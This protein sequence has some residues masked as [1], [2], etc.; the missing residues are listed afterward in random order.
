M[1]FVGKIDAQKEVHPTQKRPDR[2]KDYYR[3]KPCG[4]L[5]YV[6][7]TK[8]VKERFPKILARLAE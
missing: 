3:A 8:D 6:A 5:D 4:E 1:S 2:P 7:L